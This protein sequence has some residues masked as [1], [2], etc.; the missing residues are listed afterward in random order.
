MILPTIGLSRRRKLPCLYYFGATFLPWQSSFIELFT[1]SLNWSYRNS[2]LEGYGVKL[3]C[4]FKEHARMIVDEWKLWEEYYLP[5]FSLKG[6]TVLDAGAGVGETAVF[7]SRHGAS[8]IY[9]IEIDKRKAELIEKNARLNNADVE[10]FA[11]PFS[12]KHLLLPFDFAKIDVEGAE[13]EL[14]RLERINFPCIVEVHSKVLLQ[15]FLARGFKKIFT[16]KDMPNISIMKW[17]P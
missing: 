13:A 17:I 3:Y 5:L 15:K 9:A 6:K 8:K 16:F 14:L 1:R 2:T 10:V 12:L 4:P 7:Y 11:E